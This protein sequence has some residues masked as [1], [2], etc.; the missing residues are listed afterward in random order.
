MTASAEKDIEMNQVSTV[1]TVV[2]FLTYFQEVHTNSQKWYHSQQQVIDGNYVDDFIKVQVFLDTK[3]KL[4]AP[5]G[6]SCFAPQ[7]QQH[8]NREGKNGYGV[9]LETKSQFQHLFIGLHMGS[10]FAIKFPMNKTLYMLK[11]ISR[12]FS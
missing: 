3:V 12:D 7:T 8:Q 5:S 1:T 10:R 9:D 11:Y 6:K 4:A 2:W